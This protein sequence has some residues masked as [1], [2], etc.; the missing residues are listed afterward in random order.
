MRRGCRP[1]LRRKLTRQARSAR[2]PKGHGPG[3]PGFFLEGGGQDAE[4]EWCHG[5]LDVAGFRDG[6][7]LDLVLPQG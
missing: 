4:A 2:L 7:D 5:I 3:E 6:A 1:R